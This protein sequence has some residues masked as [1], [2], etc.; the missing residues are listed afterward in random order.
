MEDTPES[1]EGIR[2]GAS[3]KLVLNKETLRKLD[4]GELRQVVGGKPSNGRGC[5]L[6]HPVTHCNTIATC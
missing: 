4:A 1:Q 6:T 3:R 5:D 2:K